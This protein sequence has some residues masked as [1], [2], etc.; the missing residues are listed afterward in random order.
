MLEKMVRSLY[1]IGMLLQSQE[2]CS[3]TCGNFV[4]FFTEYKWVVYGLSAQ[5]SVKF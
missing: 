1:G 4:Y 3:V 2:Q 5:Y